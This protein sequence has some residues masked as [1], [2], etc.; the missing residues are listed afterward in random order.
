[1]V[2]FIASAKRSNHIQRTHGPS[3]ISHSTHMPISNTWTRACVRDLFF[4][5]VSMVGTVSLILVKYALYSPSNLSCTVVNLTVMLVEFTFPS[6]LPKSPI[7]LVN[8][9]S[10]ISAKVDSA[11]SFKALSI[12]FPSTTPGKNSNPLRLSSCRKYYCCKCL[13]LRGRFGIRSQLELCL[14]SAPTNKLRY[15]KF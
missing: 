11:V 13:M 1:M 2:W 6:K 7:C 8:N 9:D 12:A 4:L 3:R 5:Y 15:M 10:Y 14:Y